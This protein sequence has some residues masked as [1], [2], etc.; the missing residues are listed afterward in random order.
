VVGW[1]LVHI[2][3]V[4]PFGCFCKAKQHD[5]VLLNSSPKAPVPCLV[6]GPPHLQKWS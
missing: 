5:V 2:E 3:E 4:E 6:L 1:G